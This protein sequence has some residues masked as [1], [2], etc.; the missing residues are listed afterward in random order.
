MRVTYNWLKDFVEIKTAPQALADKLTMAGLEVTSLEEK[1]GD[2]VFEIEVTANRPDWLSVIGIARE[3]AA[4]TGVKRSQEHKVTRAQGHKNTRSQGFAIEIQDKKDCPLYIAR[5]I[6]EVKVGPSPDWMKK[7]LELVGCRSVNN[8]VDTTNYILFTFGEPLHAFDLDKL[9]GGMIIVR[10]GK[11]EEKITTIDGEQKMLGPEILVIADKDKPAAIAGIMGGKDTE[12]KEATKNILLEAAVFNPVLIRRGRRSL[13]LASESAY[14]FER[15]I[16]PG[17]VEQAS[18]VAAG[19]I[20]EL[21][22]GSCVLAK[23]LGAAQKKK[24]TLYLE[25]K[26]VEKNLGVSISATAINKILKSL[27]FKAGIKA[28]DKLQVEIPLH[29]GDVNSDVDLIEEIARIYG[30]DKIPASIPKI[31]PYVSAY[32]VRELVCVVKNILTGLGLNEVITYSLIDRGLIKGLPLADDSTIIEIL[33]PLSKEQEVLRPT[34]IPG[35]LKSVAFNLNQKE[36]YIN[37][38][39]VAKVFRLAS[40]QAKEELSLG[41]ALCGTESFLAQQG[42]IK[43]EVGLLHLKG[44]FEALFA[45][46]GIQDYEFSRAAAS[47]AILIYVHKEK[48]G[49]ISALG[50][51]DLDKFDIKNKI[52]YAAEV[53]LEKLFSYVDLKK[54]LQP[55]PKY[56]GI[57]RDI[58]FILKED[59]PVKDILDALKEKGGL[60]LRDIKI[61]DYYKGRQIPAGFRGLT[62]SCLYRSDERTL[63][64]SEINPAHTLICNVLAERFGAKIR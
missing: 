42:L 38:F 27:D 36:D 1:E 35:L 52:V 19:L 20:E 61:V 43:N 46:L 10:R 59:I 41:I 58:S 18:Q 64:E 9:S 11:K 21:A 3:V 28:K 48:I 26:V 24:R 4:I 49:W 37:L 63:T 31:R 12:V 17:V 23:S 40:G 51:Y 54:K 30:Y 15:G 2:V 32:G 29:R 60:L 56:P 45:R 53:S 5:I 39:E 7:R 57:V 47:G 8:I 34:V 44:V 13:G 33:N 6:K 62:V 14:R 55:L 25:R 22:G 16:D 50:G